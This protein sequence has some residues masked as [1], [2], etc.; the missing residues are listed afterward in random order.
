MKQR[1]QRLASLLLKEISQIVREEVH[2][3]PTGLITF[4]TADVSPDLRNAKI[5]YSV[6]GSDAEKKETDIAIHEKAKEIQWLL[7]DRLSL[8]YAVLLTFIRE[9]S[10][11]DS[12]KIQEILNKIEKEKKARPE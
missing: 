7:N 4:T 3:P 10:I 2:M 6:M 9:T 5:Y 12:I 11:D 8:R 1:P